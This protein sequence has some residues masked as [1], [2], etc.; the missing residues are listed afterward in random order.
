[1]E[2]L[3][4]TAAKPESA[5][6]NLP[7]A[8]PLENWPEEVLAALPRGISRHTVRFVKLGKRVLAVKETRDH[9]AFREYKL[10]RKLRK[11]D[12]PCVKPIAVVTGRTDEAGEPLE[13]CIITEH[14][15]F[16]LPYRA[17][18][19]QSVRLDTGDR[20]IDAA[21]VLLVRLH[22]IGFYWGD[23]SLSNIL[24][25]RDAGGFAAYLVDAETGDLHPKLTDGQ[26][27]YD[28][29]LART[30]IIGELFDLEAGGLLGEE[31][32]PIAIGDHLVERYEELWA[33]L[34]T[35]ESFSA[36]EY[37][38][39]DERIRRLNEVGFDV[40]EL[41]IVTAPDGTTMRIQPKV[42]DAGHH[43]RRLLRLTGLDVEDKQARRLLNDMDA[44][45]AR[46]PHGRDSEQMAAYDWLLNSF[47]PTIAAIPRD[48]RGKLEPAQLYHEVLDHR[49][50]RSQAENRDVPMPE[51]AE[52][53]AAEVLTQRP[54]EA[55]LESVPGDT[56]IFELSLD[57]VGG[58]AGALDAADLA[59]VEAEDAE[60]LAQLRHSKEE[61][62]STAVQEAVAAAGQAAAL[63]VLQ[64]EPE[65]L[66]DAIVPDPIIV[67]GSPLRKSVLRPGDED[68]P[69]RPWRPEDDLLT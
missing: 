54:D 7:W 58:L 53:Y 50:Y 19:S 25:R 49:W 18:F 68:A 39:V 31:V 46:L 4:F 27:A 13:S 44:W 64:E 9:Y 3:Q 32:D 61:L 43:S 42:V 2:S 20:L 14:L 55:M 35:A 37:W 63:A 23:V 40:E 24:F 60:K 11:L 34:T 67:T 5:L 1:V 17:V 45:R 52:S 62:T 48:L 26:R 56:D 66:A 33:A 38:R 59:A 51:A 15:Q 16:S 29:D 47:E 57:D 10:L 41:S 65:I 8:V 30:N 28:V 22:L 12:V 36:D 6:L 69:E 21:A